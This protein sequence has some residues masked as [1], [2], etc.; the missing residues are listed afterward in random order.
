MELLRGD[1]QSCEQGVFLK[2]MLGVVPLV[3]IFVV[4]DA[5]RF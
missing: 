2:G 4:M 3:F 5:F 1:R